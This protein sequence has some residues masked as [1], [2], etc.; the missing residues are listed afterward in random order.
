[1]RSLR[2]RVAADTAVAEIIVAVAAMTMKAM[3]TEM[4]A[5]ATMTTIMKVMNI[6]VM[7]SRWK[8][9]IEFSA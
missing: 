6:A 9:L 7:M 5:I 3:N 2:T 1:M 4:R 8:K